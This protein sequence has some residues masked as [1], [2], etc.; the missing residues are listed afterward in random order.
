MT[1]V[2]EPSC[3][4]VAVA[5]YVVGMYVTAFL[6][7]LTSWSRPFDGPNFFT[8][9]LWPM[10]VVLWIVTLSV[11]AGE[12]GYYQ[13]TRNFLPRHPKIDASVRYVWFVLTLPFR[14]WRAGYMLKNR[15]RRK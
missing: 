2:E 6:D 11:V 3:L 9:V 14:P 15:W 10:A 8:V 7:G 4:I 1:V 5:V 12:A 13:V